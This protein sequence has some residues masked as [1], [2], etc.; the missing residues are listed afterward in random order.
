VPVEKKIEIEVKPVDKRQRIYSAVGEY[1]NGCGYYET[2]NVSFVDTAAAD[3]FGQAAV[4]E[5]LAV[6]D[7]SR[8]SANLLRSSLVGSL[9]G[10]VKT[11]VNAG[12]QSVRVFEIANTFGPSGDK[13]P[14]ERT[15]LALACD[16]D[17]RDLRGVVE[18]VIE[19]ISKKEAT[20]F[21]P[22]D[23][24]WA[25]AGAEILVNG[26]QIGVAG[27][28]SQEVLE[29][30]GLEDINICAAEVDFSSIEQMESGDVT[31]TPIPK[32]PAVERDLSLVVDEAVIWEQ[33][34]GAIAKSKSEKLEQV[35]FVGIYRG[36]GIEPGKKSVTLK[37]RF[38]DE[39]GTL[40]HEKVDEFQDT[41]VGD[42]EK[43]T[44]AALRTA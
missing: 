36:K 13:M 40:T 6:K 31:F 1:L 2:V 14:D 10:V 38:R 7:V 4:K 37:L 23:V 27:V 11:N 41:I 15:K 42:I 35:E 21:R 28:V 20:S 17:I 9:V 29:E 5:H 24:S 19:T 25:K 26:E 32:F 22:T 12:N 33:I 16:G 39:D 18:G 43:A 44:G 3:T 8:K 34:A 30:F